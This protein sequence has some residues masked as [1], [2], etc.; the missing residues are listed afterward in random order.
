MLLEPAELPAGLLPLI[1]G[2]EGMLLEAMPS[3]AL[4]S[5]LATSHCSQLHHPHSHQKHEGCHSAEQLA[6]PYTPQPQWRPQGLMGF[7]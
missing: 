7:S 2:A 6:M 4:A 1:P 3:E 5:L